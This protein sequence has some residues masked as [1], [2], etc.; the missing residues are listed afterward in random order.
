MIDISTK[1]PKEKTKNTGLKNIKVHGLKSV[2]IGH[3]IMQDRKGYRYVEAGLSV[4]ADSITVK[5]EKER[6]VFKNGRSNEFDQ[7]EI[8]TKIVSEERTVKQYVIPIGSELTV[9]SVIGG[10]DTYKLAGADIN[11]LINQLGLL[12]TLENE[13]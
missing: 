4:G 1:I 2:E 11:R 10:K 7:T 8:D 3:M 6:P 9:T 13:C 5:E 12:I